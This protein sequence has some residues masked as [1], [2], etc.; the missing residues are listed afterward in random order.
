MRLHAVSTPWP[1]SA[2]TAAHRAAFA[3]AVP[4]SFW[5]DDLP[6]RDP[7]PRLEGVA[8]AD[9]CIVGGGFTGLWAALHAVREHPARRV[10]VLEAGRCGEGASGRNGGFCEASLTHGLGNGMAR[11]PEE[12]AALERMGAENFAGLAS[13]LE[14]LG[15]DARWEPTGELTVALEDWELDGFAEEASLVAG[16][17]GDAVVLG[18]EAIAAEVASPLYSFVL[19]I[20]PFLVLAF[21]L[22]GELFGAL[23]PYTYKDTLSRV[24]PLEDDAGLSTHIQQALENGWHSGVART[25]GLLF[26]IYT[27]FN[28]MNQIVRTL[29]F[30]FDDSRRAFEWSWR[31]FSKTVALLAVW[32]FLLLSVTLSSIL[33]I[34]VHH[35]ARFLAMP[36]HVTSDLIMICSLFAAVFVTYYL[37]PA[38][39]PRLRVVRDGALIASV[40]WIACGLIFSEVLP[41]MMG[42]NLVYRALGSIVVILLWA[43]ACSWSLI[44]GA[45]WMVRFSKVRR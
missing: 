39:P 18:R 38:K 29:L 15:I 45:C 27:S 33:S 36:W 6:R 40:G 23:N 14:R 20:L 37:V 11:F 26:A 12:M 16:F 43:Q 30:I 22:T 17:G 31:V 35:S 7:E 2:P 13:D 1:Q 19:S 34:F 28:L 10:V 44:V 3:D 25:L 41:K 4:R 42:L 8:E 9:L 24:L 5:L 21:Y 32:T